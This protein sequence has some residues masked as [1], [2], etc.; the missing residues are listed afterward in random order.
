MAAECFLDVHRNRPLRQPYGS[1]L[2]LSF[3]TENLFIA[4]PFSNSLTYGVASEGV[5]AKS[6]AEI[7]QRIWEVAKLRHIAP[8]KS[9]EIP[10]KFAKISRKSFCNDPC[11]NDSMSELPILGRPESP[12][13]S[14]ILFLSV[15]GLRVLKPSKSKSIGFGNF[16]KH[17]FRRRYVLLHIPLAKVQ[18]LPRLVFFFQHGGPL[19]HLAFGN[20]GQHPDSD[21][22]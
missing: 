13:I 19:L 3:C 20:C 17:V 14:L 7:L 9:A 11:A 18:A 21:S 15:M 8:G 1:S 12:Y 10:R 4:L 16:L 6:F 5:F 22:K 2:T